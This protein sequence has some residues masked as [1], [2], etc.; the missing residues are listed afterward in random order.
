MSIRQEMTE[1]YTACNCL[2]GSAQENANNKDERTSVPENTKVSVRSFTDTIDSVS[3]E[4][5]M[6]ISSVRNSLLDLRR[7]VE[8]SVLDYDISDIP[9][10]H[11]NTFLDNWLYNGG[12]QKYGDIAGM[13]QIEKLQVSLFEDIRRM[14]ESINRRQYKQAVHKAN[15]ASEIC[16]MLYR[17]LGKIMEDVRQRSRFWV[18]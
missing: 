14:V 18:Q 12:L 9:V 7:K 2:P 3:K 10:T 8:K 5:I 17:L 16:T 1:S 13:H 15:I 11:R 4:E 6:M